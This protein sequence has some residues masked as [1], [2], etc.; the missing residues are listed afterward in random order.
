MLRSLHRPITCGIAAIL[1]I[2]LVPCASAQTPAVDA[3]EPPNWWTGMQWNEVQLM[4]YGDHLDEVAATVP[5]NGVRVTGVQTV[6][7]DSYAF[8]TLAVADDAPAQSYTL[9][10]THGDT[11]TTIEYPIRERADATGRYAGFDVNDVVYLITPDRFA[12]SE[13]VPYET[14]N[15]VDEYDPSDPAMRH[16]GDLRGITNRLDYLADLGV[17]AIWLNPVLENRGVDSYHGY[18]TTDFYRIDPRF[19][20]N[21]DYR[22]LVAEARERG[23]KVIFDHV[24]NHIG[25]Q[26]PWMDDLPRASWVHGSEEDHASEAHYMM[27]PTDP[28]AEAEAANLLRTFWFVDT[29]PDLNQHDPLLATYLIQNTLW[30]IETT[31]LDGIRED[32]Y[33]YAHPDFMAAWA[34]AI[35]NEYPNFSIVG[36]IWNLNPA[37]LSLYQEGSP[38]PQAYDTNLPSVMDFALSDA[39]RN[40]LNGSGR[41]NAIYE[42]LAQDY[43]YADPMQLMTFIDNHDMTRGI[44]EADGDTQ[45]LKQM[46]TLLLTTP[47]IPQI[48][49]GTELNLMGGERHIDIREPMPGG[50]P[51]DTRN[52][53][54][55]DGRT[56]SEQDMFSFLQRLLQL[57]KD[58][59]AL[60]MGTFTHYQPT[61]FSD[62]YRYTRTHQGETF[63]VLLNGHDES[64]AVSIA[65]MIDAPANTLQLTDLL[66]DAPV[67]VSDEQTVPVAAHGARVLRMETAE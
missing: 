1:L 3:V 15:T 7:S 45:K 16:G 17:T 20:T 65:E 18:K 21:D 41:L 63:I 49:Y 55:E 10:L 31:G 50:F 30:W 13:S 39:M 12:D 53:F 44:F 48:L 24:S 36:E 29:M 25:L 54:T 11:R 26:H 46:L 8:V 23:M 33:P 47:R 59:P 19:G 40:Y 6:P 4:L 61:Y 66:S 32:T 52:A 38:M 37:F 57:R 5:E 56:T 67:S 58:E 42:V 35:R 2:V 62:V 60:R 22:T 28:Y 9:E 14:D 34:E 27:A 64:R 43:L 51:G